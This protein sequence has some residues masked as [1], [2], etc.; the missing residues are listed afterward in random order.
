MDNR[1][2]SIL[3]GTF[4]KLPTKV[5]APIKTKHTGSKN[6]PK[7]KPEQPEEDKVD[8]LTI[9]SFACPPD[10]GNQPNNNFPDTQQRECFI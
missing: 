6:R 2:P 5:L 3:S 4:N 10:S 1:S 7:E 8:G 9:Q